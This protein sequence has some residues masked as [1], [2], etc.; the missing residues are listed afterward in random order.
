MNAETANVVAAKGARERLDARLLESEHRFPADL[1][2]TR[3]EELPERVLQFG[4][5]NFLRAFVDWML[6]AMNRRGIFRGR[7]VVVQ[8]IAQGMA[9]T[10]NAQ[11]G[12]YTVLLRGIEHG[13]V[14]E[15]REIVSSVSRCLNPYEDYDA[16]LDCAKN[17]DLRFVVSNTTEAGIRRDP[18]DR[19]DARPAASFP[20]KL[21]QL[22]YARFS[23]FEGDPAR[24][25]VMLPCEL[26]EQNGRALEHAVLE[27]AES[28]N[29]PPD[30]TRFLGESCTFTSTLVDRI[31][32]GYPK[33]ESDAISDA[34]GYDDPLLVTG[35]IFHS[36]VIESQRPI[37]EELPLRKAGLN[38][39]WTR[40]ITPY[41]ERKVRILNGAH[42]MTVL[43]AYLAGKNT[44]RECMDDPLFLTFVE[45]GIEE[46]ILP[47]L[48]LARSELVPFAE[49]VVERFHNPFIRHY[50]LSIALNSVSKYRTRIL[51]TVVDYARD[52]G[53]LPPRLTFA[54]AALIVFY[55][56]SKIE[57]SALI[58]ERNGAPYRI[59]DDAGVLEFFRDAWQGA[60]TPDP[61]FCLGLVRRVLSRTD[62][63]G[64]DLNL[65]L[66]GF[67]DR[68]AGH[69]HTICTAGARAA[70]ERL[71][72]G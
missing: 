9:D 28:W 59:Q 61:E 12:L 17:P 29:L 16:F 23:R 38:V 22:L 6:E 52:N 53:K 63:W 14:R 67:T 57:D 40:D 43:A 26:I 56:G 39:V 62:F 15:T 65:T 2:V 71:V 35:E 25:L 50:L 45:R 66:P 3:P 34:L 10:I 46:E 64:E 49:A 27:T 42:T 7:A 13:Q 20:G 41:R 68:V 36:W 24:G 4:E 47:T 1:V 60:G 48:K 5:G 18:D 70:L 69:V 21:T 19:L 30:F 32:T 58:G 8:P 44:V 33:D 54:L 72:T 37:E 51:G 55:R 11:Q 31:V